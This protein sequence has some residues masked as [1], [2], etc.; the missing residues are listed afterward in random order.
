LIV[1]G[2]ND[3]SLPYSMAVDAY[4]RAA[5]PVW[6]VTYL[7]GS[8]APPFEDDPSPFD[9]LSPDITSLWWDAELG[10][11]PGALTR[12]EQAAAVA[13]LSTLQHR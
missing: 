6:F 9:A 13:D 8:H 4:T 3:L 7:G 1:H 12:F 10:G 5:A 11:D 2:D